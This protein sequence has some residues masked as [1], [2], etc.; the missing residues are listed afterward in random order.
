MNE[1]LLQ[2]FSNSPTSKLINEEIGDLKHDLITEKPLLYYLRYN[3]I[4]EKDPLAKLGFKSVDPKDLYEMSELKNTFI[5]TRIGVEAAK[6][7]IKSSH[8]PA[9]FDVKKNSDLENFDIE[10]F[11]NRNK[12]V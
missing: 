10:G 11:L 6:I 12:I 1:M 5:L 9:T 2:Y 7:Q 3:A 4:L 8:F